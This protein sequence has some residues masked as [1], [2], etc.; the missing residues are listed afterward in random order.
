MAIFKGPKY[1]IMNN[2]FD[3]FK[4]DPLAIFI[5]EKYEAIPLK[6]PDNRFAPLTLLAVNKGNVKYLGSLENEPFANQWK[7]PRSNKIGLPDI[8]RNSTSAIKS[9]V[10]FNLLEPFLSDSFGLPVGV[11]KLE[12]S[13]AGRAELHLSILKTEKKFIAAYDIHYGL[14][15]ARLN[16]PLL[17]IIDNGGK[18]VLID[19][20]LTSKQYAIEVKNDSDGS[21]AANLKSDL[22]GK[23]DVSSI[24]Q[25]GST[26]TI[27][28]KKNSVFA[29]TC[30]G[31][32]MDDLGNV[33]GIRI[34]ANQTIYPAAPISSFPVEHVLIDD[35]QDLITIDDAG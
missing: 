23:M 12:A 16:I 14:T 24:N 11:N 25:K 9:G 30:V 22:I 19:A 5:K 20:V 33:K 3:C 26:L 13:K 18:I 29:F 15:N 27:T 35:N 7:V 2:I 28:G 6:L 17:D 34:P 4:K 1:T 8:D 31:L 32:D 10:L 21:F